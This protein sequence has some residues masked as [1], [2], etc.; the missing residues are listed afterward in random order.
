MRD[1]LRLFPFTLAALALA[2]LVLVAA[3]FWH[4][5]VFEMPALNVIGIEQ[6][7][8]GEIVIALLLVIPASFIAGHSGVLHRSRRGPREEARG[9]APGRAT[10]GPSGD[11]ADRARDIVNNNLNQL[12]LLSSESATPSFCGGHRPGQ[13]EAAGD[14]R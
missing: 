1:L 13:I 5:N 14:A 10:A 11:H 3:S 12:Q 7:E 8:I 2:L 9:R 4:I 6:S